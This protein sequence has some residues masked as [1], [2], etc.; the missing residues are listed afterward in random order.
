MALSR[1]QKFSSM[2]NE[3]RTI[4]A[5]VREYLFETVY[6]SPA[7][8]VHFAREAMS[9]QLNIGRQTGKTYFCITSVMASRGTAE[10]SLM[11]VFSA[12]LKRRLMSMSD[13]RNDEIATIHEVLQGEYSD[14]KYE[15]IY[16]DEPKYC[17]RGISEYEFLNLMIDDNNLHKQTFIYI[18]TF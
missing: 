11:V 15:T 8:R 13:I 3:A 9:I 1:A 4:N 18:G 7:D 5:S 2:V 17:F 16:V 12:D 6:K 14:I 10:K